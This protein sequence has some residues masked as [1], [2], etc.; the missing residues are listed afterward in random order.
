MVKNCIEK[1]E[2]T[3]LKIKYANIDEKLIKSNFVCV[4][5][6]I[7]NLQIFGKN[8]NNFLKPQALLGLIINRTLRSYFDLPW[9]F[10]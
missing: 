9:Y 10:L 8:L 5:Y 6:T 1:C 3:S 2:I 4:P 7:D